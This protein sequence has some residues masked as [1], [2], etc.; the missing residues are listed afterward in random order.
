MTVLGWPQA[1]DSGRN[2]MSAWIYGFTNTASKRFLDG[3]KAFCNSKG[4]CM[5]QVRDDALIL[6]PPCCSHDRRK[7][8]IGLD[9]SHERAFASL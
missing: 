6:C 7:G 8:S 4:I 5:Q 1:V 3:I 2:T 9:V